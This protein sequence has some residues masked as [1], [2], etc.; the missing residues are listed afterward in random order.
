[1]SSPI[2]AEKAS[3]ANAA[4]NAAAKSGGMR[5]DIAQRWGKFSADEIAALKDKDDLITQIQSKYS[6]E[7][8]QALT[9]VDSFAKGRPL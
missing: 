2:Q 3:A 8:A 7:R 4:N 5:G 6:I 1:M 9:D